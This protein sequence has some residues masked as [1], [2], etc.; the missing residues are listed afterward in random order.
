MPGSRKGEI[1]KI[2]PLYLEGARLIR[3]NYP[4]AAFVVPRPSG[5]NHSDYQGLG[6]GDP[7]FFV[8]APAY[9]LRQICDL[10]WVK[11]GTSTLET[12][13]LGIPMIVVYKVAALTGFLAKI[14][15]KVKYVSLVNLLANKPVVTELLQEKAEPEVLVKE[16]LRL[17]ES[18]TE[19]ALQLKS[20]KRIKKNIS[21]PPQASRNVAKE[22]LKLLGER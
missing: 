21:T 8:D 18:P 20:F 13:L 5:L 14:F 12:A 11:S 7:F 15:L 1:Q 3:K 17:L 9:D 6:P 22:I 10:A 4:D 2:W 16:T 19:R